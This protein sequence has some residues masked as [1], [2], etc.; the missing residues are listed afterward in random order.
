[1]L[2]IRVRAFFRLMGLAFLLFVAFAIL[3]SERFA[4]SSGA[5]VGEVPYDPHL[6]YI[7]FGEEIAMSRLRDP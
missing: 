6:E 7:F 2:A 1:M 3:V 5:V 4:F